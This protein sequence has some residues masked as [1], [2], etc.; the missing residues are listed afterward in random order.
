M[1]K[2]RDLIKHF[3]IEYDTSKFIFNKLYLT[4][5]TDFN[6]L[7]FTNEDDL[8]LFVNSFDKTISLTFEYYFNIYKDSDNGYTLILNKLC[9]RIFTKFYPN[10]LRLAQAINSEYNP[11]E[12]Y[13]MEE[14]ENVGSKIVVDTNNDVNVFGYNTTSVDGVP[15]SKEKGKTTSTGNFADNQRKLTRAGNIGVT[16]T[17]QMIESSITLARHKLLDYIFKDLNEFLFLSIYVN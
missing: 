12:N 2:F 11:I 7:G 4:H 8:E 13:S 17:Q 14:N 15:N 5:E 6:K 16:T 1:M 9:D 3:N 10:W